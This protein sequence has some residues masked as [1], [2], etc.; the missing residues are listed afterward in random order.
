MKTITDKIDKYVDEID[1]NDLREKDQ[2]IIDRRTFVKLAGTTAAAIAFGAG[3]SR[4]VQPAQAAMNLTKYV[5][6]LVIPPVLTPDTTTYPGIDYYDMSMVQGTT[7]KFHRDL[8]P[9]NTYSYFGVAPATGFHYLGP[10]IVANKGTPVKIKFTNKLPTGNHLLHSAIDT[11]IMGSLDGV[12]ADGNPWVDENRV[13]VHLHGGKVK[14]EFDGGP[15]DWFSP[16]GSDQANPYPD[17]AT[18]GTMDSYTYE[19]SNDQ[20]ATLLWYHD[21]AW[22]ITRFNPFAGLAAAYVL[23]DDGENALISS[24]A[25]PSGGYEIPI[26]LQ[27]RLLDT[28]TG[29]MIYPVGNYPPGTTHPLWIPEYFGDTPVVNG[30]AYPYLDVEQRR[31][32]FRFL[33]G[34]NARFYNIWFD[35]GL[36]PIPFYVIGSEQGFLPAPALVSKLLIAPGERFDTIVDF[37]GLAAGTTLLLKNNAKAPYPG[38]KGGLGQIMQ[39][40]VKAIVGTDNT[41]P[42]NLLTLPPSFGSIT[43]PTK[44]T[45]TWREIVLQEIMDP[46]SG[47]PKE[48]LLD[49]Y[50]FMDSVMDD[51]LFSEPAG[52]TRVW[53]FINTTGDAHPMHTHLVPFKVLDRQPFDVAGFTAAWNAWLAAGRT[54]TRPTV[55]TFLTKAA[56]PPAP[57]ETGWK[58]TAKSYPGEVLRIVTKFELP[59]GVPDGTYR[60]VCHC[61]ILEHE[62]NDMM[63]QFA[64]HKP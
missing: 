59:A 30:K 54:G 32:R 15:R 3:I 35:T 31:Y 63:F 57:E 46:V 38:G 39:F 34:S 4:L 10:T 14:P 52:A 27:D 61:H 55:D 2:Y 7:H 40:R 33:N 22:A 23:R 48:V 18:K 36:G 45:T 44:S 41:T 25:I 60:Y 47:A 50:H 1:K 64:V 6:A 28:L 8:P 56:Y 20:P 53:Q 12:N 37:T 43:P 5:D 58:D 42:A 24:G 62:E 49:G 9:T 19:Y 11:T 13:C 51:S 26:V 21:H 17:A 16:K 29:A